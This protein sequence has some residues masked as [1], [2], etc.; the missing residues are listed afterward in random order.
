MRS[1]AGVKISSRKINRNVISTLCIFCSGAH[2]CELHCSWVHPAL[3]PTLFRR[4]KSSQCQWK[5]A[6]AANFHLQKQTR[7]IRSMSLC[8]AILN[9][10]TLQGYIY[11]HTTHLTISFWSLLY[12]FLCSH[13]SFCFSSNQEDDRRHHEFCRQGGMRI[14]DAF[15]PDGNNDDTYQEAYH[16]ELNRGLALSL[17]SF[18]AL[19]KITCFFFCVTFMFSYIYTSLL[20]VAN[21]EVEFTY[22]TISIPFSVSSFVENSYKRRCCLSHFS[23]KCLCHVALHGAAY[24]SYLYNKIRYNVVLYMFVREAWGWFRIKNVRM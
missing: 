13:V 19:I 11:S 22:L 16:I 9:I 20:H 21:V 17:L 3:R 18:S 15:V 23:L 24:C 1:V 12:I 2:V 5:F 8:A 4:E 10:S 6:T 14:R 7:T